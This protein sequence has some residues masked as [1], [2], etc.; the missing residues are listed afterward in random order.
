MTRQQQHTMHVRRSADELV[1]NPLA[2]ISSDRNLSNDYGI[3]SPSFADLRQ[4]QALL[5]Y[6]TV[7]TSWSGA[8]VLRSVFGDPCDSKLLTA[9][10]GVVGRGSSS[11]AACFNAG[12]SKIAP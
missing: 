6:T 2:T 10:G 1:H 3:V 9:A 5:S 4:V 11:P 12:T 8:T 7:S